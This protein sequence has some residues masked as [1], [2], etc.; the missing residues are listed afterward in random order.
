[1]EQDNAAF[2]QLKHF[3]WHYLAWEQRI[4][5]LVRAAVLPV[6]AENRLPQTIELDALLRAKIAGKLELIWDE[7]M[8]FVPETKKKPNPFR[9]ERNDLKGV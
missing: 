1:M 8:M 9:G 5:V 2:G 3:F 4:S 6:S 7:T